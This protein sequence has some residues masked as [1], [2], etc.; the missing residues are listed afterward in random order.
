MTKHDEAVNAFHLGQPQQALRLFEE[1]LLEQES[2]ELWNDWATVQVAIGNVHEAETGLRRAL[3]LDPQNHPAKADLGILMLSQ[4]DH[5]RGI[6][7][8]EECI[9]LL[10]EQQQQVLRAALESVRKTRVLVIHDSL[11]KTDAY[12]GHIVQALGELGH[13]VTFISREQSSGE[14]PGFKLCSGDSERLP[15]LGIEIGNQG[16]TLNSV[17]EEG[18][19]DLAVLTQ[20]FNRGLSIPEHYLDAIRHN[21]PNTRIAILS[22]LRHGAAAMARAVASGEFRH[23]S[24]PKTG[25]SAKKKLFA[26]P[27]FD[28]CG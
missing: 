14:I 25:Q 27:T 15:A 13:I 9:S 8:I 5:T 26:A 6:Q 17:L 12:L 24:S 22:E 2:S 19:F 7:L 28:F 1:L 18:R 11:P 20:N 10:P 4:G 23:R 3:Q 21:S 16:W